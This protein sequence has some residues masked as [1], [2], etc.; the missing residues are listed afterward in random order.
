MG[1]PQIE[2]TEKGFSEIAE[3]LL[4]REG[5][6]EVEGDPAIRRFLQASDA[7]GRLA[8]RI[9]DLAAESHPPRPLM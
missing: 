1:K 7:A 5:E 6:I 9:A 8:R 3:G 2:A 4:V